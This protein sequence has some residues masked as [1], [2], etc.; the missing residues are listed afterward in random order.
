VDDVIQEFRVWQAL[1]HWALYISGVRS[2]VQKW[3]QLR[4][5]RAEK[6]N[7]KG[8]ELTSNSSFNFRH[9]GK[10]CAEILYFEFNLKNNTMVLWTG[11]LVSDTVR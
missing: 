7:R 8:L 6:N 10:E 5:N 3:S 4:V 11:N 1:L 2:R 9:L